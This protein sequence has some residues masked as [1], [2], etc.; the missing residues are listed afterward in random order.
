[1]ENL[2]PQIVSSIGQQE[3]DQDTDDEFFMEIVF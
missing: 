2:P 3:G 1:M